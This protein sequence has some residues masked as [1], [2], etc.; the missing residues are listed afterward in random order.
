MQDP[1]LIRTMWGHRETIKAVS[2]HPSNR[3][4]ASAGLDSTIIINDLQEKKRSF[5]LT[6][7]ESQIN[8]V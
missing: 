4:V 5:K 8:H 7:H 2:I 6:G 1:K 3:Y